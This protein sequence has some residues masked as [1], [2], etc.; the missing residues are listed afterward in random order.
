MVATVWAKRTEDAKQRARQHA[1]AHDAHLTN[2]AEVIEL[3]GGSRAGLDASGVRHKS[4]SVHSTSAR[5]GSF[6]LSVDVQGSVFQVADEEEE[7]LLAA[8]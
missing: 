1:A 2:G 7:R 3:S 5:E 4:G 8:Q 6:A